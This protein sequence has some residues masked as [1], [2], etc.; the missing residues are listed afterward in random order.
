MTRSDYN[1]VMQSI[2][3]A[4]LKARLSEQ[5]RAVKRGETIT[6][7]ERDTPVARIIP[8]S[9]AAG[10]IEIRP[11]GARRKRLCDVK[12]PPRLVM[13]QDIV[14]LLLEERGKR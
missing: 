9:E 11:A 14:E 2:R 13:K 7:L 6:V 10:G 8:M 5:L 12:L 4:E 3:V 1:I